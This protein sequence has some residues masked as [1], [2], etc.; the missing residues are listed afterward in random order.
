MEGSL[1]LPGRYYTSGEILERELE[2][3][4]LERWVC[5]GREVEVA[6]PG[7]YFLAQIGKE[8][9]I[10][11]RGACGE[12]R[13]YYNVCRHRGSRVAT[14]QRGTEKC[15][16]CP[17]HGWTYDL[18]G[19]VVAAPLMHE[20]DGFDPGRHSLHRVAVQSWEGFLFVNLSARPQPFRAAFA[21]VMERFA[22]WALPKLAVA[23]SIEYDIRAN[24]KLVVENYSE[25][26]HCPLIHEEFSRRCAYRSGHNDLAEGAFLGG[27]MELREGSDSLTRS[28]A[29]CGPTLGSLSGE[30]LRRV[31]FYALFPNMT[32]SLHPDYAMCFVLW[33]VAPDRTKLVCTW[34]FPQ[35][36]LARG[37]CSPDD[38]VLFW[39]NAN[40]E[41]WSVCTLVQEGVASRSYEPSPY[42]NTESLLVSFSREVL[43]ALSDSGERCTKG[44]DASDRGAQAEFL[45]PAKPDQEGALAIGQHPPDHPCSRLY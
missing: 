11:A 39:D 29:R 25:C 8:S 9:V 6:A 35:E 27:F 3:I 5:V 12:L 33:P 22:G 34:L 26:Y 7:D 21:P 13:A 28:G 30:D 43:E 44:R 14:R 20:V 38:A 31:Y 37:L 32:L 16:R 4:F 10:I 1:T 42:S 45:H 36:A 19:H 15:F 17:Y 41:D 2:R 23:R 24:W 18:G 40:R